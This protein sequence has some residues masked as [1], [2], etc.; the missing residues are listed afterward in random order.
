M[1]SSIAIRL[2][3]AMIV[4]EFLVAVCLG[5]GAAAGPP[6]GSAAQSSQQPLPRLGIALS[7]GTLGP[8]IQVATA[9]ER[10][11]NV[12]GGFN[13]FS[14]SLSGT[15]SDNLTYNGSLRLESGEV[16][17]DYYPIGPFHLSGGALIYNGF[18]GKGSVSVPGGQTLTLNSVTYYSSAA[19]PVTG[20]G[21]IQA[22][23]FAPMAL[24]GFGNLLPR[25]QRH[26]STN[27][28]IG[29]AFQGAPSAT[30]N[31][32]GSTCATVVTGCAPISAQPTVQANI[33]AEQTKINKD[34]MPFRFYPV[35]SVS[36]GYKF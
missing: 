32:M 13:Y 12:R 34:L 9:V 1:H 31:L 18:Q 17:L 2:F 10:H 16:L 6:P 33:A 28:D 11:L 20:N 8:G 29:V 14:Y 24:F 23:K 35:I 22:K 19:D 26:F 4:G 7:M 25:S 36:F 27:V 30:L 21:N 5:Q 15:T 3:K